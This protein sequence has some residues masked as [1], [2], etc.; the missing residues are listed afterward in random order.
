MKNE[1][2][3]LGANGHAKVCI[4]ILKE[5][6]EKIDY[7]IADKKFKGSDC[8]G[9]PVLKGDESLLELKKR[10][11]G[12]VFIGIGQ[13]EIR[14]RLF[15]YVKENGFIVVNAISKYAI[16]SSSVKLGIGIA[17]MPGAI[18]N[19][20]T[21]VEDCVI[22]NTGATI[23][24]DCKIG[25]SVHIAPQSALAGNVIIGENSFLGIGSVVI[26]NI[27]I[28]ENVIIGAGS[29]V[30]SDIKSNLK[31]VGVPARPIKF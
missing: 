15:N 30:I 4:E 3:M 27:C 1:I 5:M 29:V 22:I 2:I 17:V 9:I 19:S 13:N 14:A 25:F 16:I 28:A 20:Q 10:G 21:I 23:D 12:R 31:V 7:C 8:L 24:H 11:Y 26:P 18:I 6:G